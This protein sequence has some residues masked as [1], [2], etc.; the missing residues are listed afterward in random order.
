[1]SDIFDDI[2]DPTI[3]ENDTYEAAPRKTY[4]CGQCGGSGN[5]SRGVNSHG[6]SKCYSCNGKGHFFSSSEDRAKSRKQSATR[7][8]NKLA[9][10]QAAF[11]ASEPDLI[12]PLREMISW[13]SFAMS[14]LQQ[15]TQRGSLSEK[16]V[17]AARRMIA[18]VAQT[19]V[20]RE[21]SRE[22][23]TVQVD[24]SAIRTLFDGAF[25]KG[26]KRPTYRAEDL[27]ISRAP[28]SGINA[29]A[30]YV[31]TIHDEYQGKLVGSTFHPARDV[32]TITATRLQTIAADPREAAV[33]YGRATGS[34]SCCGREL[35]KQVSI[36]A[37][38]GPI[39]ASKWGL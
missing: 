1:M 26:L 2:D 31:K 9:D 33:R 10:A 39:C 3:G 23:A 30:L 16:Q 11:I 34:C 6:V 13:N 38:I 32:R 12:E 4:P 5:W 20:D 27:V 25:A 19:K 8:A 14:L 18:K 29:G 21:Q 28:D 35:T 17:A 24:L 15:Y 36:D 37:G 7:T 22:D